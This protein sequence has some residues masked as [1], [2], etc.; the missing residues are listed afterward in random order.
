M[1]WRSKRFARY[2]LGIVSTY[3]QKEI[4]NVVGDVN[5]NPHLRKVKAV[6]QSDESKGDNMVEHQLFEVLSRLLQLQHEDDGLL[7][8]IGGLQ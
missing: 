5:S 8:P 1:S 2:V 3:R 7:R 4:T 6:A